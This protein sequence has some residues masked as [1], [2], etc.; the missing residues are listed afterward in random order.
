MFSM[1]I[2]ILIFSSSVYSSS[3]SVFSI[4][5]LESKLSESICGSDDWVK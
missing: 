3:M 5:S 1:L 4:L 2:S